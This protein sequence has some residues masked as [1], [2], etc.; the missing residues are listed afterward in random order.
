VREWRTRILSLG[1]REVPLSADVA[2]R[3]SDLE[4]LSGD[5]SDRVIVAT[6]LVEQA[7]LVTADQRILEWRGELERRDARR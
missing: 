5:P 7:V 3:A 4:N 6:A 1:V 2:M